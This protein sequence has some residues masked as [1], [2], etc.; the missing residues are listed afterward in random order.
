MTCKLK[1]KPL[2]L[3][4]PTCPTK[5]Y[6]LPLYNFTVPYLSHKTTRNPNIY[7]QS[8]LPV[9]S[10]HKHSQYISSQCPTCPKKAHALPIYNFRSVL[11]VPQNHTHSHYIPAESPTCPS[12]PHTLPL[13]T[14]T[15]PSV[16]HQTTRTPT[17]YLHSTL[18]FPQNHTL[19]QYINSQHTTYPPK[20]YAFP[21]YIFT[22][23][24]LSQ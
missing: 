11:P 7:L 20:P 17:I 16:S 6:A 22:V 12:K 3:K 9:P 8:I 14:F 1:I 4:W 18:P 23:T 24:Y 19:S 5:P 21:L 2:L 10:N 13:H 15:V